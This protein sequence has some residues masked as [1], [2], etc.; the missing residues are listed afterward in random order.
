M[1]LDDIIEKVKERYKDLKDNLDDIK[2]KASRRT[3][4]NPNFF[5]NSINKEGMNFICEINVYNN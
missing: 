1:I 2:E 5:Y 3:I 4:L